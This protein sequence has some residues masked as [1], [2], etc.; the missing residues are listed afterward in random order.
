MNDPITLR[1]Y[2][3]WCNT[4]AVLVWTHGFSEDPP[5]VCPNNNTH[6][7]DTNSI[8]PQ[9]SHTIDSVF[10][11]VDKSGTG[12]HQMSYNYAIHIPAVAAGTKQRL[13]FNAPPFTVRASAITIN[14]H[15][16]NINDFIDIITAPDTTIGTVTMAVDV[17]DTIIEVSGTV[18]SNIDV[19]YLVQVKNGALEE[20]LGFVLAVD[21]ENSTITVQNAATSTWD[22]GSF[23]QMSVVRV[24]NYK[25]RNNHPYVSGKKS[26][27]S[28]LIP[29]NLMTVIDY[30]SHDG[31]E[32][33]ICINSE[34]WY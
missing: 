33:D 7:I 30:T 2:S 22:A 8:T 15:E 28:S 21:V 6:I 3:L 14:P 23:I 1:K 9:E 19:G 27:G 12:G 10:V 31:L 11:D 13:S 18:I 32:K 34:I 16:E 25:I 20:E 26:H 17:N 24:F 4:E 29:A 5:T